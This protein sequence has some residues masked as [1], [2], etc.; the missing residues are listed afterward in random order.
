[1]V[2]VDIL[3]KHY[4]HFLQIL[5]VGTGIPNLSGKGVFL[6]STHEAAPQM[7]WSVFFSILRDLVGNNFT[8]K[9][10]QHTWRKACLEMTKRQDPDLPF[11][12]YTS[13]HDRFY[14]ARVKN[15]TLIDAIARTLNHV[16]TR[17]IMPNLA[18]VRCC[19]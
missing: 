15:C 6:M 10:V 3:G 11:Y 2:C 4:M 17:I 12:Y 18:C 7:M 8:L 1:M 13:V 5:R 14:E 9:N 19:Y 16:D